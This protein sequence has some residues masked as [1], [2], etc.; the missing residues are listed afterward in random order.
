[1]RESRIERRFPIGCVA[2]QVPELT[3]FPATLS[4]VP[5]RVEGEH[6]CMKVRINNKK[7]VVWQR[8]IKDLLTIAI[9]GT[10]VS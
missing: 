5:G 4:L 6:M 8:R 3:R 1:M 2:L 10:D 9:R 7:E